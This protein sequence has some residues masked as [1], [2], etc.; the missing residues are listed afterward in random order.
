MSVLLDSKPES[1]LEIFDFL[2]TPVFLT[3]PDGTIA[4][5][6]SSA[7]YLFLY[8][9]DDVRGRPIT[10]VIPNAGAF[11]E[12]LH[13]GRAKPG[14]TG[15]LH[16]GG[17]H[18]ESLSRKKDGEVI[19]A[20]VSVVPC[21]DGRKLVI[22]QD[23]STQKKLQQRAAQ[24][25]KELSVFNTFSKILAGHADISGIMRETIYMLVYLM[26][27]ERGWIYLLDDAS[28]DLYLAAHRGFPQGPPDHL[29]YIRPGESFSGKV[30][31]S[32]RPLLVKKA[33][34]DPRVMNKD[35]EVE[36][37]AGV[38]IISKGTPLGVLCMGSRKTSYFTSLDTQLLTTIANEL[39]V[40]IENSRLI[41]QLREKMREI[42]LINELSS[43]INSSLSI[44]TVFRI[45]MSEIRKHIAYDRGSIL[46]YNEKDK[47]LLIYALDT[48]MKTTLKRGVRAPLDG[49][50]AGWVIKNNQP[51]VNHDLAAEVKFPLDRKLLNE[52]IRSTISV[53][54]VQDKVLGVF[55]LDSTAPYKYSDS[56]LKILL[57][58]SKHIA[59]ALEN[60]LLFEEISREKKEW[61][62]TFDAIT[63]MLW[64][65]DRKQSV[66]RVNN[67]LLTRTGYSRVEIIGKQ[68]GQILDRIGISP[69]ECLCSGTIT[70][71]R[72][73]FLEL[74]GSGG[75]IFHFWAYPLTD[76]EGQLY[77]IVHYLKD[78]TAQKRLE[79][80][81][82]RTDKL[83]SLG[84]LVAGIAHEINNPLGII[85]G[86]SEALL[87]RAKDN[88][89]LSLREFED[90]PEY[91]ET[92]H[93]E[94]FRCKRILGT[95]LEFARPHGGTFRE[96]DINELI[97][98]V[99]LLVNHRAAKLNH[100]I[101]FRLNR[102][103]PK[104]Y[105]DPGSLRQ[106]FMNII[107][108]SMYF[109]PGGGSI[110]IR[111]GMDA[112][113]QGQPF[114]EDG[115]MITVSVSDTGPGIPGDILAK[116]F[117]PFFTTKP[118]GDGTGLGLAICHKIV[119][120]H[121]G[122]IDVESEAGKGTTFVIRLPARRP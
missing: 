104:I 45:M 80:Q 115:E 75:A 47:N 21:S 87:E 78:V 81:L 89:L 105:A 107:I 51:W 12:T 82:I 108:N 99:L 68:C 24:R 20:R 98:E 19:A 117:D 65:E 37:M 55:N 83:A 122:S 96:L 63:D 93:N 53:P 76:D 72:P 50:S 71:K 5:L 109:T 29:A 11:R 41:G 90:F 77:A 58:V 31:S 120:E 57:S 119:E 69:V 32:G 8:T 23:I 79:Q 74:K 30:F 61:E 16:P 111:T 84:T 67:A 43:V 36:S 2:H 26:E 42:G 27:T 86:Y 101:E 4:S 60:A 100:N 106:L 97:K 7:S 49:I 15:D 39:G 33:S 17:I 91:L 114:G 28:G 34:E 103:L 62:G 3:G 121:N 116:I 66:L 110:V 40:A 88:N 10:H 85:A 113:S 9:A 94:M 6:N 64:I 56:D 73:S 52:G 46:L 25:A 112:R 48:S 14:V 92:I 102:E 22:I 54:L 1:V 44:G 35:P 70:S 18:F 13:A 118:V 38:P 59:I 95:L